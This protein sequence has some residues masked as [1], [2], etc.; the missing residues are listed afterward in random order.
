MFK[1]HIN[2]WQFKYQSALWGSTIKDKRGN[3]LENFID[4]NNLICMNSG[5]PTRIS[6]TGTESHID[7][8]CSAKLSNYVCFDTLNST[9]GSDHFPIYLTLKIHP[10]FNPMHTPG[11]NYTKADWVGFQNFKDLAILSESVSD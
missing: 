8:F 1:Q 10:V 6:P 3:F 9:C 5:N 4:S 11:Y 7:V 2:H